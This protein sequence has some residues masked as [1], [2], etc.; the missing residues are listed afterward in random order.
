MNSITYTI[1]RNKTRLKNN[2]NLKPEIPYVRFCWDL[3]EHPRISCCQINVQQVRGFSCRYL[4]WHTLPHLSHYRDCCSCGCNV[5]TSIDECSDRSDREFS[6]FR[7]VNWFFDSVVCINLIFASTISAHHPSDQR[8]RI[9][10]LCRRTRRTFR[11]QRR[12]VRRLSFLPE[13]AVRISRTLRR[14]HVVRCRTAG[15][16]SGRTC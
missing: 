8:Q 16:Q 1:F 9:V 15:M 13:P 5:S 4:C 2:F 11:A 6:G 10:R 7:F 12:G 14:P 3:S